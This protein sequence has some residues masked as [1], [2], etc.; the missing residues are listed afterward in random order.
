MAGI[1]EPTLGEVLRGLEALRQTVGQLVAEIKQDRTDAAK[2]YLR[3]DVYIAEKRASNAVVSDLQSDIATVK[4]ELG[5]DIEAMKAERRA[6]ADKRRQMWLAIAAMF[7][8]M[9]G[10]ITAAILNIVQG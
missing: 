6:D 1:D 10:I 8:T 2:T 4:T 7:I 3:Q 9:L 5:R